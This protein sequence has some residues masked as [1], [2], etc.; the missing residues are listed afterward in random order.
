M[1]EGMINAE[2]VISFYRR[3]GTLIELLCLHVFERR[4]RWNLESNREVFARIVWDA[5]AVAQENYEYIVLALHDFHA[6]GKRSNSRCS[7]LF[8]P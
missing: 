8:G 5:E 2:N 6:T 3:R 1:G 7:L 4:W